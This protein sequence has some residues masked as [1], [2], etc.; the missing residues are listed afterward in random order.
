MTLL[1]PRMV[2]VF[3]PDLEGVRLCRVQEA[4][5]PARAKRQRALSSSAL[6]A[7]AHSRA[8]HHLAHIVAAP[9]R[10]L[11]RQAGQHR[12]RRSPSPVE[13]RRG[14]AAH[15]SGEE[16]PPSPLAMAQ[17][18]AP[19]T[20]MPCCKRSSLAA[21]RQRRVSSARSTPGSTRR[22][23]LHSSASDAAHRREPTGSNSRHGT[24]IKSSEQFKRVHAT[25]LR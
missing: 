5:N 6:S 4:L 11:V 21:S 12:Q 9:T 7:D 24:S 13:Q 15:A 18:R 20:V 3:N 23:A 25:S 2:T 14:G 10:S 8:P 1:P 22:N 16:P 17:V 19:Q